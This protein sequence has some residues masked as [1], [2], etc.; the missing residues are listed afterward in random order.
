MIKANLKLNNV[1]VSLAFCN[2]VDVNVKITNLDKVATTQTFHNVE[3]LDDN[4]SFVDFS[5]P[6]TPLRIELSI[7]VRVQS[8]TNNK[9][10]N[11]NKNETFSVNSINYG[12]EIVQ[13]SIIPMKNNQYII[14]L[15]GKNGE[16]IPYSKMNIEL[17]HECVQNKFKFTMATDNLGRVYLPCMNGFTQFV[18]YSVDYNVCN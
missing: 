16:A 7:N 5:L 13:L 2:K 11:F 17:T 14:A 18:V 3:L 8:I 9:E 15:F 6:L 1:N 12:S 10:Y 4:E